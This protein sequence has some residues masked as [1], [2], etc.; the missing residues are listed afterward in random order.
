MFGVNKMPSLPEIKIMNI[1]KKE[2]VF[3]SQEYSFNDLKSYKNEQLRF[4]FVIWENNKIKKAIEYD[5]E[6]HFK[7]V[8]FFHKN[9]IFFLQSVQRDRQKNSYCLSRGIK[10][11][12]IPYWE[13]NNINSLKDLFQ[14][15]FLVKSIWHNDK[16]NPFK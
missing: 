10:L 1:L 12:R 13:L 6:I 3:F 7:Y 11:Y 9:K 8:P 14:E 2:G 4:D 16:I 5:S 15:K